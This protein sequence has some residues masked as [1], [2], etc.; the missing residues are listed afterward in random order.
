M[1]RKVI[2][3]ELNDQRDFKDHTSSPLT[4]HFL[5]GLYSLTK[6]K[7]IFIWAFSSSYK[8]NQDKSFSQ[9]LGKTR[10][11]DLP[12]PKS[13]CIMD[14]RKQWHFSS[15]C[16]GPSFTRKFHARG[17]QILCVR[18]I[19]IISHWHVGFAQK[20]LSSCKNI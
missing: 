9:G 17:K 11:S 8:P 12:T 4:S 14:W 18:R 13:I 16:S 19:R 3:N 7:V 2:F 6:K 20:I 1:Q 5:L 10:W 15:Q